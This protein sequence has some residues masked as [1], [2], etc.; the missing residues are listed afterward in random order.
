MG[1]GSKCGDAGSNCQL[2]IT[3][4]DHQ[5]KKKGDD[6]LKKQASNIRLG[7]KKKRQK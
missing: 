3:S 2:F 6:H 1:A 5:G 7:E 4:H